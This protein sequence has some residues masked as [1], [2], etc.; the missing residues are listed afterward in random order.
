MWN[1]LPAGELAP[2]QRRTYECLRCSAEVTS[3]THREMQGEG[4]VF[5]RVP[6]AEMRPGATNPTGGRDVA[7]C[8]DCAAMMR[9]LQA[10][11]AARGVHNIRRAA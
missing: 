6:G 8:G 4:W 1:H 2:E 3:A 10:I 9:T 7:L 5:Y 11:R